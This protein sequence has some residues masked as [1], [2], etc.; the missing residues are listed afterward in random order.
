MRGERML[1][2]ITGVLVELMVDLTEALVGPGDHLAE[3]TEAAF[4]GAAQLPGDDRRFGSAEFV[5]ELLAVTKGEELPVEEIHHAA[6]L[7]AM[8]SPHR[9]T[10]RASPTTN[11]RAAMTGVPS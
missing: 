3:P 7:N 4:V 9:G 11:G 10:D 8:M 2:T 6:H 1:G 5:G